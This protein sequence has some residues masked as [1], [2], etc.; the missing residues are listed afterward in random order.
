MAAGLF[1]AFLAR[2][3]KDAIGVTHDGSAGAA[4]VVSVDAHPLGLELCL[5][6]FKSIE[7]TH[8]VARSLL[9]SS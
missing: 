1:L 5:D 3:V 7:W 9:S 2:L 8:V 6:E 4:R